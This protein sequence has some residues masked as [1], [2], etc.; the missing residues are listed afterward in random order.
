VRPGPDY[1][2]AGEGWAEE[3]IESGDWLS[4][5][6]RLGPLRYSDLGRRRLPPPAGEAV[7]ALAR[8]IATSLDGWWE[9]AGRPDPFTLVVVS[10]DDGPLVAGVLAAGPACGPALRYVVVDPDVAD[11]GERAKSFA[12]LVPLEDPAFLYPAAAAAGGGWG[13]EAAGGVAGFDPHDPD[14]HHPDPDPGDPDDFDPDER[15]PARGIGPLAT[16]LTEV[17]AFGEGEGAVVAVEVL[18]R[19]RFDLFE[20]SDGAWCEV[21]LEARGDRLVEITVPADEAE[22]PGWSPAG[23]SGMR[24]RRQTGAADWLRRI[25]PTAPG[26]VLAVVDHWGAGGGAGGGLG[27]AADAADSIDLDQLRHVREPLDPVPRPVPGTPLSVVTW[28]L[29]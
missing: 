19:Q 2:R 18:S 15:P 13:S 4:R 22:S 28:R 8:W 17:P 21:R 3:W 25:R 27:A 12:P 10:G 29:G 26:S 6:R 23:A 24:R 1:A 14:P 7:G 5:A 11:R 20:W 16:F 9:E